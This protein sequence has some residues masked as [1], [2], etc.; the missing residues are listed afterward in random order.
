[1]AL[2]A[3]RLLQIVPAGHGAALLTAHLQGMELLRAEGQVTESMAH[4]TLATA[5]AS[6]AGCFQGLMGGLRRAPL[7]SAWIALVRMVR[8]RN[9][10]CVPLAEQR[11]LARAAG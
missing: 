6:M 1:M 4:A 3:G 8:R 9:P 11:R 2:P 10:H 7:R 5:Q